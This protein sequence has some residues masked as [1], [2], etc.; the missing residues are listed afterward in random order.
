[1]PAE[2]PQ[3][4]A[5][6]AARGFGVFQCHECAENVKKA[7]QAAGYSGTLVEIR[8]KAGRDFMVC[9]S[10]DGGQSTITQNGRHVGVRIGDL[11]FDNLHPNGIPADRWLKDFDAIGGVDERSAV[12]F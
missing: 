3:N 4:V 2:G 1:V 10:Y 8:G 9:L 6:K 12:D 11:M 5:S 7:L